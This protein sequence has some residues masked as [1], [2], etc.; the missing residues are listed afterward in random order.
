MRSRLLAA[1]AAT[2]LVAS[3]G[4]TSPATHA[5]VAVATTTEL[6]SVVSDITTCAGGTSATLM[7]PGN[8]PHTFSVSSGEVAELVRAKLVVANGLGLEEGLA[9]TLAN[10]SADGGNVVEIAPT[11][12]PIP[13]GGGHEAGEVHSHAEGDEHAHTGDDPHFWMD[14]KRMASAAGTIGERLAQAT[15]DAR[16][17]S[18]GREV[19]DKLT[20]VDADVRATLATIPAQRRVLV[21]DH[22]AYAYFAKAYGFEIAG[23]VI[24]GGSTD[25]EPSSADLAGVIDTV[26]KEKV[27]AI[28][29]N[30]TVSPKLVDTVAR[31]SGQDVKVVPLYV[32]S[33][34][35]QGSGAETYAGMMTTNAR[36]I[37]DALK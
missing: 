6:G 33:V 13:F 4:C 31:E 17:A 22:D 35:P 20:R 30:T 11:I 8:D 16:Y 10:V 19:S 2:T 21:T 29:S 3:A 9:Q 18:C 5:P 28:F 27:P 12:D 26:K 34:G 15:G 36:L 7:G 24:P 37:A 32:D 1:L 23:V 25:A 14:V